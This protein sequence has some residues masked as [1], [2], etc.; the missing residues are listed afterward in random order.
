LDLHRHLAFAGADCTFR[1]GKAMLAE[2]LYAGS[3]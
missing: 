3:T 1:P 2:W